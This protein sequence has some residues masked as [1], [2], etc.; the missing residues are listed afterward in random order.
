[1]GL[2]ASTVVGPARWKHTGAWGGS[3][4]QHDVFVSLVG[5][6]ERAEVKPLVAEIHRGRETESVPGSHGVNLYIFEGVLI[7]TE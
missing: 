7:T 5:W 2:F 1:M 4:L 3:V 6:V